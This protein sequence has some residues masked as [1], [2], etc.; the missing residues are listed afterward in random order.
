MAT[1]GALWR[2]T[3]TKEERFS[4]EDGGCC[5]R[6]SPK[7]RPSVALRRKDHKRALVQNSTGN[8]VVAFVFPPEGPFARKRSLSAD[9]EQ[10][11]HFRQWLG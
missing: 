1:A 7:K 2:R 4:D 10:R 3:T 8:P 9:F 6:R 11:S 5:A